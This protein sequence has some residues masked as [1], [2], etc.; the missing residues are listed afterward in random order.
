V[1]VQ[2]QPWRVSVVTLG[3]AKN[4]AD[5]DLLAGQIL[6][7]GIQITPDVSEADAMIINTCAFLTAA[8]E[9]SIEVVLR[10]AEHKRSRLGARLVVIGCLAQRHAGKLLEEIPEIDLLVGPGEVHSLA[11][12]LR[13]LIEDGCGNGERIRL[14]GTDSIEERWDVRLV[15][16]SPHSAYVKISEGCS[17]SCSFCVIPKLRGGERS[18]SRESILQEARYLAGAGVREINLVAQDLTG[19][20][21]DRYGRP[22]LA[23]LL[24]DLQAVDGIE[25]IRLL[26]TYPANWSEELI[27]AIRGLSRV[28]PYI[29]MPIQHVSDRILRA[30]RRPG[31]RSTLALLDRFR[32][33][34]PSVTIRT[35]LMTGFPGE[36]DREAEEL[37]AFVSSYRFDCLGVFA[38][39]PEEGT[40]AARMPGQV[41]V[42]LAEERRGRLLAVQ[43][44]IS[45]ERNRAR[46]GE[47]L[48]LLLDA[49]DSE[50]VGTAR[51]A[52]QAPEV[53]GTTRMRDDQGGHL[54]VGA[55]VRGKVFAADAY[56]LEARYTGKGEIG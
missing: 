49:V 32:S 6:R 39:S 51:H 23:D 55:M 48:T 8:Q 3:C 45:L 17:R 34:I 24:G 54:K 29:D 11:P 13:A 41:P 28:V 21:I 36:T 33:E 37:L 56:D 46:I 44:E 40:E 26:Y 19:Y 18:R 7:E 15:S 4:T 31:A 47:V 42:E 27:G 5:T 53:D 22:G 12:R 14:G 35:T 30:M 43:Q 1:S 16:P 52:G 38:F 9:E 25:W 2:A 50:G 20:G 10:M